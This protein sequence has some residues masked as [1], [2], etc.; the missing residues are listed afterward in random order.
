MT[1]TLVEIVSA[2]MLTKKIS[3]IKILRGKTM[4]S[5]TILH[6][7]HLIL[8]WFEKNVVTLWCKNEDE[9]QLCNGRCTIIKQRV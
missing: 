3:I 5:D 6:F 1:N 8:W 7:T 4:I 9:C 2:T